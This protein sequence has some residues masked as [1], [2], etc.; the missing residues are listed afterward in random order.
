M[1]PSRIHVTWSKPATP[2]G[3]IN[4]YWI[5]YRESTNSENTSII[6]PGLKTEANLTQLAPYT[7]YS[8]QIAAVNIR[9]GDKKVLF[10]TRSNEVIVET[11]EAGVERFL[12]FLV[13]RCTIPLFSTIFSTASQRDSRFS[14]IGSNELGSTIISQWNY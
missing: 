13:L 3:P 12:L 10:G 1:G 7:V 11:D 9:D 6:V 8:I 5:F 14:L 4:N 2:L